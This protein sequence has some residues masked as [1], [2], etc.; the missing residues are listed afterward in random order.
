MG[1]PIWP[2]VLGPKPADVELRELPLSA[3]DGRAAEELHT[4]EFTTAPG[5]LRLMVSGKR[6]FLV[7]M[8]TDS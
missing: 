5:R 3:F 2:G 1:V 4:R 8:K 6:V 7:L